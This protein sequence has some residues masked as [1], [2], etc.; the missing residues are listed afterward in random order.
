VDDINKNLTKVTEELK[1]IASIMGVSVGI[2]PN[3]KSAKVRSTLTK[4]E[5][6]KVRQTAEE[7][8]KTYKTVLGLG[9]NQ[10]DVD[11]T[12]DRFR[13]K[14]GILPFFTTMKGSFDSFKT[15]LQSSLGNSTRSN[16]VQQEMLNDLRDYFNNKQQFSSSLM[17]EVSNL[18]NTAFHIYDKIN[19]DKTNADLITELQ[20]LGVSIQPNP[21]KDYEPI[22]TSIQAT[23]NSVLTAVNT[24]FYEPLIMSIDATMKDIKSGF[25]SLATRM[26]PTVADTSRKIRL[27]KTMLSWDSFKDSILRYLTDASA[28]SGYVSRNI[29][30]L[31]RINDDIREQNRKKASSTSLPSSGSILDKLKNIAG[32]MAIGGA[33][34]LIIS[35]LIKAG[36]INTMTIIKVLGIL[37]VFV[38]MFVLIGKSKSSLYDASK[39]FGLLS[40]TILLLIIPMFY[41]LNKVG[42]FLIAEGLLKMSAIVVACIGLMKVMSLVSGPRVISSSKGLAMLAGV[43]GLIVIPLFYLITKLN[44]LKIMEGIVKM[45]P[46]FLACWGMV[47]AMSMIDAK[48]VIKNSTGLAILSAVF[49][50]LLIPMFNKLSSINYETILNGLGKFGLAVGGLLGIVG[51]IGK[52]VEKFQRE[53]IVGTATIVG[54]SLT[55]GLIGYMLEGL[56][57]KD[58]DKI[59]DGILSAT[60]ALTS[61]GIVV[62]VIGAIALEV[63]PFLLA[64]A[65]TFLLL[66]FT[67]G[68]I[69]DAVNKF[70]TIDGNKI[71]EVGKGLA[72]LSGGLLAFIGGTVAGLGA[73]I[74]NGLTSFFGL[75]PASQIKEFEKINADKIEK[76]GLGLSNMAQGLKSLSSGIDLSNVTKQ[77]T[78]MIRPLASLTEGLDKF[79]GAYERLT[80]TKIQTEYK[81]NVETDNSIQ[82]AIM[83]LNEQELAVQKLQLAQ[84]QQNGEYLRVISERIR[85]EGSQVLPMQGQNLNN[86]YTSPNITT[87]DNFLNNIKLATMSFS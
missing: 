62:G 26:R 53:M 50:F 22:L 83:S 35:A 69:A 34:F 48:N 47:K 58:W 68:M 66:S 28:T 21:S 64:G 51:L 36:M 31:V 19:S 32:L 57:N 72:I 13:I 49:S 14:L 75:D 16:L 2:N 39:G 38:G 59:N 20:S 9:Y 23:M 24:K 46:I 85:S 1:R 56:S 42:L 4:E 43:L 33:M 17:D 8:A 84:L 52:I 27:L 41:A 11:K 60:V 86:G 78:D 61:F 10:K 76:L 29:E 40:A 30:Q 5:L 7:T 45:I 12:A 37:S 80:K 18:N 77:I 63:A 65:G 71:G 3:S 25:S 82:K 44:Y 15:L 81:I 54:L 87:K 74:L 73:G 67:M 6:S 79:S 70:N 55:L